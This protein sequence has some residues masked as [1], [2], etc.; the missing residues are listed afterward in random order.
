MET[1]HWIFSDLQFGQDGSDGGTLA[2]AVD[3]ILGEG[4][5]LDSAWLLGDIA[6][7]PNPEIMH[8]AAEEIPA[9]M[10]RLGVAVYYVMGN[11]EMDHLRGEG[12]VLFPLHAQARANPRWHAAAVDEFYFTENFGGTLVVFMGDHAAKDGSWLVSH[13]GPSDAGVYPHTAGAYAALRK[14]IIEHGGPVVTASHYA[15]DGGG[16]RPSELLDAL[17]PLPAN[18][19]LHVHGHAHIGDTIWNKGNPWRRNNPI[20]D[21]A[22]R[23]INISAMEEERSPGSHSAVLTLGPQGPERLRIRCSGEK[24]WVEDYAFPLTAD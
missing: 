14:K 16:Q 11:H 8:R 24:R 9:Q 7:G 15:L 12:R 17:L 21:S 18:V 5:K 3:D 4:I 6:Y 13:G 23:Q 2:R 10:E 20:R 1:Q 22:V 19:T